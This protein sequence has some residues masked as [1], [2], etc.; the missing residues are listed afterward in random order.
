MEMEHEYKSSFDTFEL[1]FTSMAKDYLRETSKWAKFLAIIGFIGIGFLVL[2]AF[3]MFAMGGSMGD[4]AAMSGLGAGVGIVYLLLAVLYFFPVMYLYKFATKAKNALN[5]NNSQELTDAFE[6]MKS[7][8][9]FMG[10]LAII[11]LSIYA[12][13]F[14]VVILAGIGAAM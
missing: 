6:N 2:I 11:M 7:H 8:Y 1:Q 4:M 13:I 3:A 9:K 14:V 12:L 10:I 5:S